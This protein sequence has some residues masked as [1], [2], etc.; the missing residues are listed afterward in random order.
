MENDGIHP[1]I[2]KELKVETVQLWTKRFSQAWN[3][4]PL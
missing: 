2:L 1:R 4:G 3:K